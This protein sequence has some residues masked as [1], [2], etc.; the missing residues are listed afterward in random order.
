MVRVRASVAFMVRASVF[1][2]VVMVKLRAGVGTEHDDEAGIKLTGREPTSSTKITV[3]ARLRAKLEEQQ[4]AHMRARQE[5]MQN[6]KS[7]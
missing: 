4:Q 2:A 1:R 3:G 6:H 7:S 5:T